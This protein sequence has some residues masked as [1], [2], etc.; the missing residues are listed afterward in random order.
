M[1]L[2][3][4]F[5][6]DQDAHCP[7]H[8]LHGRPRHRQH[9][10]P[11]ESGRV[12]L[13]ALIY[14]EVV[15]TLA[16]IGL[17]VVNLWKP[18]VGMNVDSS[19]VDT[20]SIATFTARPKNRAPSNSS[21]IFPRP[22][23]AR[24]RPR[25][26]RCFLRYSVRFRSTGAR[27]AASP[28]PPPHRRRQPCF[29]PDRRLCDEAGPIGAFGAMAFTIVTCR[30][31]CLA[32]QLHAVVLHDLPDL[33][34]CGARRHRRILRVFLQIH[35]HQDVL[36]VRNLVR[37]GAAAHDRE[38]ENLGC[39][40]GRRAGHPD[41]LLFNLDGTCIYLTMA[42]IFLAQ[43][44]NTDLTLWQQLGI[45]GDPAL[46]S[47]GSGRHRLAS[48][49]RRHAR[50]GWNHLG[51]HRAHTRDRPPG[52][53]EARAL[54]NLIG[55]GVATVVVAKWEDALDE[56]R[57][58]RR[59]NQETDAEADDPEAVKVEDDVIEEG[60]TET[61]R[62]VRRAERARTQAFGRAGKRAVFETSRGS[63]V[64]RVPGT[65]RHGIARDLECQQR[66][67]EGAPACHGN[68]PPVGDLT[69]R[70][71]AMPA[72]ANLSGD[73]FGG[74]VLSQMDIAGGSCGPGART[75][76]NGRNR[77]DDLS[78]PCT[79]GTSSAFIRASS[80]R[81]AVRW[82]SELKR[83][84]SEPL[85]RARQGD[86]WSLHVRGLDAQ[87]RPKPLS[88]LGALLASAEV[89]SQDATSQD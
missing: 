42:A 48:S 25:S 85:G 28:S 49:C 32:G 80:G 31:P 9:E 3:D 14:F 17:L 57:L 10:G 6:K 86:R 30:H 24:S 39:D 21:W 37:I 81:A 89:S 52:M 19:T 26:C 1:K 78:G 55:N 51:E 11:E 73:I 22:S 2:G 68:N 54:T 20:K 15:T 88:V 34:L 53:S 65:G 38:M 47:K 36:I 62:C 23:S 67:T 84:P 60:A 75:G 87:G 40:L 71:L 46:T 69:T 43:A 76:G 64:F 18:G 74:W 4:A 50:F 83:G 33:Y 63:T 27:R 70:T 7:D 5:I 61:R 44:T 77:G 58:H 29:L 45:I 12:G 79:S 59:L 8:L 72:D 13:K 41:G 16:L 35:S 82:R 56:E 66:L